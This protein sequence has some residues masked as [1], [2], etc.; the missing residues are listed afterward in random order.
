MH[1]MQNAE[2]TD[3]AHVLAARPEFFEQ[4]APGRNY[5]WTTGFTVSIEVRVA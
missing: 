2:P 1:T 4:F 3:D 5:T